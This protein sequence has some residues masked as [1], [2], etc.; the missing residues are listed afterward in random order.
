MA[1]PAVRGW[2]EATAL[3][4]VYRFD[5]RRQGIFAIVLRE[6]RQGFASGHGSGCSPFYRNEPA[7][8]TPGL[9]PHDCGRV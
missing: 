9:L 8:I 6:V 1:Y 4:A 3:A 2:C 7:R 5:G